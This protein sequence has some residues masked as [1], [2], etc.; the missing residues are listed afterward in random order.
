MVPHY[1]R[2]ANVGHDR[3]VVPPHG[4]RHDP[5]AGPEIVGPKPGQSRTEGAFVKH[6]PDIITV[7]DRVEYRRHLRDGDLWPADQETAQAAGIPFDPSFG[8]DEELAHHAPKA[9][10]P[11][12]WGDVKLSARPGLV[13]L[14]TEPSSPALSAEKV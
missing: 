13:A 2:M 1:E 7:P 12:K 4:W 8:D 3:P 6:A 5:S 14:E 10:E 9:P 11:P